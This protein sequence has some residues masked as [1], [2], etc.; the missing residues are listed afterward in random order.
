MRAAGNECAREVHNQLWRWVW[1]GVVGGEPHVMNLMSDTMINLHYVHSVIRILAWMGW[2]KVTH[3]TWNRDRWRLIV[4]L[5][6]FKFPL[7]AVAVLAFRL[8]SFDFSHDFR[9]RTFE[10]VAHF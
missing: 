7:A 1:G 5:T 8:L 4:R 3:E 9:R 10:D 6:A 2:S